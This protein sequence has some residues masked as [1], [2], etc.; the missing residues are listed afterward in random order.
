M[1]QM[2]LGTI[3]KA[4]EIVLIPFPYTDLSALKKRPVLIL[5][6]PD[7]PGDFIALPL[8]SQKTHPLSY[9]LEE[10][11]LMK[12]HLPKTSYVRFDK[13]FTFNKKIVIGRIAQLKV[14]SFNHIKKYMCEHLNCCFDHY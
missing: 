2:M 7:E 3:L 11:A 5:T 6:R 10:N 8:T 1:Q 13:V 9:L 12:G 14:E 4:T